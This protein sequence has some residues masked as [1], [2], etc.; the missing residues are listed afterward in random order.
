M[1]EIC[2]IEDFVAEATPQS[3][4]LEEA[5]STQE[6]LIQQIEGYLARLR[7]GLC[8]DVTALEAE[9]N[10]AYIRLF[11]I[12]ATIDLPN[13][14]SNGSVA[15]DTVVSGV[16]LGTHFVSW[17]PTSLATSLDDLIVT[18]MVVATD[19]IR[20]VLF[21]PTGGAINPDSIDFEFVLGVIN[22]EA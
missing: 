12:R 19:T 22:P 3:S 7:A 4:S 1:S 13:V 9:I 8:T 16:P 6:L 5:A 10:E 15:V 20:T 14:P 18:W 2:N 17:A 21:N 11:V